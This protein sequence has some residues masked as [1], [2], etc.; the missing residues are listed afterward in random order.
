MR[1]CDLDRDRPQG[2][3]PARPDTATEELSW[4]WQRYIEDYLRCVAALDDN[5]GAP[6]RLGSTTRG[7][8]RRHASSSTP[9]RPGLLPRRPRLVRQA[10]H[11]RGVA[12]HAVPRA[13]SRASSSRARACDAMVLNVDFAQT[14]SSSP[15]AEP[16][17]PMQG[18][19]LAPLLRGERPADWRTSMYYRYWMHLDGSARRVG[20]SRRAHPAPQARPLLRATGSDSPARAV[21]RGPRSGSCSTS[22]PIRS[23][24]T[25]STTIR[26]TPTSSPSSDPSSAACRDEVGDVEP[27]ADPR[28]AIATLT[29]EPR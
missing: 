28:R 15:G 29:K 1:L 22:R 19:S 20:P 13:L 10:L 11:V 21:T 18:R 27:D 23:S 8:G 14:F 2:A 4:R 26:R 16:T 7:I 9:V 5:V 17:A 24:C 12:A 25:A 3:R 6:A